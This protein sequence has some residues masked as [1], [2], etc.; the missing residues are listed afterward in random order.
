MFQ[1]AFTK[2]QVPREAIKPLNI[3]SVITLEI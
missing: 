2:E 3:M 1:W